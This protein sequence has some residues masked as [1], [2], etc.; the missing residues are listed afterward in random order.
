MAGACLL[1]MPREVEHCP[2][3]GRTACD[4]LAWEALSQQVS[5]RADHRGGET[6]GMAGTKGFLWEGDDKVG[7][8][9]AV[10]ILF[11]VYSW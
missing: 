3:V 9:R 11:C 6:P 8:Q 10:P 4:P 5:E 7:T 2:P 1:V